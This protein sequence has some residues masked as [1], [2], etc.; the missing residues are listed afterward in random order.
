[1][2]KWFAPDFFYVDILCTFLYYFK[3]NATAFSINDLSTHTPSYIFILHVVAAG[4]KH[5]M[6]TFVY[7]P[8]CRPVSVAAF[9]SLKV[10]INGG[11][12]LGTSLSLLLTAD[13]LGCLPP[14]QFRPNVARDVRRGGQI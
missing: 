3:R 9:L 5:L 2:T 4:A 10:K 8:A 7:P 13:L 11:I 1:M 12:L 6:H 14:C